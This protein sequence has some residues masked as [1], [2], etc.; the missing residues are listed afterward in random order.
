MKFTVVSVAAQSLW[1]LSRWYEAFQ[2]E[3]PEAGVEQA[4][5]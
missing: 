1:A 3:H 4:A 5:G 2:R